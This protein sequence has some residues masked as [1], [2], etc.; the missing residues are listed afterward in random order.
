MTVD[1]TQNTVKATATGVAGETVTVP[2]LFQNNTDLQVYIEDQTTGATGSPLTLDTDYSVT[3]AGVKTGGKVT[4][5]TQQTAGD[6]IHVDLWLDFLQGTGLPETG[7]FS[8]KSHENVFDKLT[9]MIQTIAGRMGGTAFNAGFTE[10]MS[11]LSTNVKK[12]DAKTSIIAD[13]K[14]P[15][16]NQ[17]AATK[18]FVVSQI[19]G[20]GNLPTPADPADD[21][22][23]LVASGGA[24]TYQD[25]K[26]PSPVSADDERLLEATGVGEGGF[27][28]ADL[29]RRNFLINGGFTVAQ[30]G[31]SFT[32]ASVPINS[33]D[34]YLLDRWNL[35]S[36]GNDVVDVS[37]DTTAANM[38]TGAYASLKSLVA[39]ANK[40]WGFLQVLEARDAAAL[41]GGT[42]SLSFDV[43]GSG[44]S[45]VR[46]AVLAWDGTADSV[47]SDIV[48]AWAAAGTNPTFAT[49]WTAENTAANLS[50]TGSVV[51]KKIEGI[52]IDTS[53]AKNIAIFIWVDD[54]DASVSDTLNI[55]NVT[56]ERSATAH[57]FV[58]RTVQ[59]EL[60]LCQR[61]YAKTFDQATAP[62]ANAGT[63][64][65]LTEFGMTS[66]SGKFAMIWRYPV[67]MRKV[68]SIS[69]FNPTTG[70]ATE[71][72]N[73]T[74]TTDTAVTAS[75][76]GDGACNIQ[77]TTPDTLDSN[78]LM[79]IH[80]T[81]DAEL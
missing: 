65:M 49:N 18:A 5:I 17:D 28:F 25:F 22:K 15:V 59:E 1:I 71:A 20:S 64:G 72:N 12:W 60:A 24:V 31:T 48:S 46:A 32:A 7:T 68:P 66:S 4:M 50:V 26:I 23:I 78:D 29:G 52:S 70:N 11:R 69:T 36:D 76:I 80:A 43:I 79:G 56:L 2:F 57:A 51:R 13:V 40:K 34:T 33:D 55:S 14:D 44:I 75:N 6:F 54:T 35:L 37:Q 21:D 41:I 30:R 38:P 47:T 74:S 62:I 67:T 3:G 8:P 73:F 19:T 16:A 27:T 39:T 45:N 63:N 53:G 9:Q 81:A 58:P 42:V 10:F 61:Y 77:A